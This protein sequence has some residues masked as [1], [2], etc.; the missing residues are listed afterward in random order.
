MFLI[1]CVSMLAET[2]CHPSN[3]PEAQAGIRITILTEL[4]L[5]PESIVNCTIK[6]RKTR[7]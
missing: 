7:S 5:R 1:F 4:Y 3:L 2:K 6:K